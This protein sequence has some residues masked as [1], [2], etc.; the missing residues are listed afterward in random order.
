MERATEFHFP[1]H[2]LEAYKWAIGRG[3]S[4]IRRNVIGERVLGLPEGTERAMIVDLLPTDEQQMI[5]D[6]LGGMLGQRLPIERLRELQ[7]HAGAAEGR[8]WGEL[9]ELGL[10]G[11][12]LPEDAGGAGMGL[13]EEV[14]AARACGRNLVSTRVL[15]QMAVNC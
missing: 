10:F 3:T 6:S 7:T 15:A 11:L 9:A 2:Y 8:I 14:I 13:P 4:E 5:E 1:L 12:G